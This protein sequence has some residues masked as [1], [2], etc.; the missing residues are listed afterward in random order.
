MSAREGAIS[1]VARRAAGICTAALLA[2]FFSAAA[3]PRQFDLGVSS[4]VEAI[5]EFGRQAGMLIVAPAGHLDGI[6]TKA[7]HGVMEPREAL[8]ILLQGTGLVVA[9][10]DGRVI[11]LRRRDE[12]ARTISPADPGALLAASNDQS[13]AEEVIVTAERRSMAL[14]DVPMSLQVASGD[15]IRILR[16]TGARDLAEVAPTFAV[17]RSYQGTPQFG[18]RGI[19]FNAVNM[20]SSPTVTVY[21]GDVAFAYPYLLNGPMFDMRRIEVLKGPQG[22]LYGRNT[23]AG[24]INLI[25]NGPT[26]VLSAG[27]SIDVGNY[28]TR[29][30]EGHVS[31]PISSALRFRVSGRIEDSSDGWQKYNGPDSVISTFRRNN[32][33]GTSSREWIAPRSPS[34]NSLGAVHAYGARLMLAW[35]A[36]PALDVELLTSIWGNNSDTQAAQGFALTPNLRRGSTNSTAANYV[37]T[38]LFT[39]PNQINWTSTDPARATNYFALAPYTNGKQAGWGGRAGRCSDGGTAVGAGT[40][41]CGDLVENSFYF[42]GALKVGYQVAD[43]VRLTSITGYNHLNRESLQDVSGAPFELL[44]QN[45]VGEIETFSQELRLEGQGGAIRWAVSAY[46]G[47]AY[48]SAGYGVKELWFWSTASGRPI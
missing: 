37:A 6:Q 39:H 18:I 11:A 4:A 20:S 3:E 13:A 22:T 35:E 38:P 8:D 29:N 21:Q 1:D 45:P 7:V 24:L 5:P 31:G 46:Y 25:P 17:S 10:D 12:S 14:M 32:G 48:Q 42:G 30:I 36:S 33:V 26:D 41:M 23:T 15:V 16:I 34:D 43:A 2:G 9:S 28:G 27:L 44:I 47:R 19:T 40:G